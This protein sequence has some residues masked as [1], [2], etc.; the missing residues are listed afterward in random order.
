[1]R[2]LFYDDTERISQ[3]GRKDNIDDGN[4]G[5]RICC[6]KK[7]EI[8]KEIAVAPADVNGWSL[9]LNLISWNENAPRYD[10]GAHEQGEDVEHRRINVA[11]KC[12]GRDGYLNGWGN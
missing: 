5:V 11:E 4:I 12:T 2:Q 10:L 3:Y 8:V 1:M 9:Q 6:R 7:Y